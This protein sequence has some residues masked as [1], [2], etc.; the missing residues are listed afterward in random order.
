MKPPSKPRPQSPLLSRLE[1]DGRQGRAYHASK[2]LEAGLAAKV[3]GRRTAGSGNKHEKGDVRKYGVM[4]IE[5]KGTVKQSFRVT[6]EQLEKIELAGRACDEIPIF[7][8]DFLDELG[9]SHGNEVAVL[10][11]KDL[12]DLVDAA[13]EKLDR[14]DDERPNPQTRADKAR[15]GN[16]AKAP[17]LKSDQKRQGKHILRP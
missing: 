13:T 11:L 6:K 14:Q 17:R 15:S 10:P 5:H 2:G 8:V 3:G 9:K 16:P 4:R 1:R 12:L 7:T